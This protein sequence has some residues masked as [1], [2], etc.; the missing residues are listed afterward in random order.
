MG[1]DLGLRTLQKPLE[2]LGLGLLKG[3][4]NVPMRPS[5]TLMPCSLNPPHCLCLS[6]P[7]P[8]HFTPPGSRRGFPGNRLKGGSWTLGT[9]TSSLM[10]WSLRA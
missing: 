6:T 5:E 9:C 10:W 4:L 1:V 7:D 3:P 8:R 2:P